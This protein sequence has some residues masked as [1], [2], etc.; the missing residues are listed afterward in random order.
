V[1]AM[2][3]RDGAAALNLSDRGSIE[4]GHSADFFVFD[5]QRELATAG[6]GE[7]EPSL[8]YSGSPSGVDSVVVRGTTVVRD[9]RCTLVDETE[10]CR[11]A[12][13]AGALLVGAGAAC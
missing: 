2:A 12:G 7:P 9:G 3:T 8:V 13:E 10:L 1:L 5:P 6:P 11:A 4:V